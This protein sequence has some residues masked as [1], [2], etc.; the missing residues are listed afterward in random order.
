MGHLA[1]LLFLA[2]AVL[3]QGSTNEIVLTNDDGW[4]VAMIRAQNDALR[5]AGYDV[6]W[7]PDHGTGPIDIPYRQVVLSCPAENKSGTGSSS[8]PP[9]VLT[10]PCEYD[11]CPV[12][13]PAEGFNSSDRGCLSV[14]IMH[15][16]T[17]LFFRQPES[18]T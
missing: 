8:A 15:T 14:N 13:S 17:D 2:F 16:T 3:A 12:G 7:P 18:T 1:T 9:T 6:G 11:T 5:T 4:A 10:I